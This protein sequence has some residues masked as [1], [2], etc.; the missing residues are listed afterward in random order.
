MSVEHRDAPTWPLFSAF[1]N[2]SE[3]YLS[4]TEPSEYFRSYLDVGVRGHKKQ[5][6]PPMGYGTNSSDQVDLK[7]NSQDYLEPSSML[8]DKCYSRETQE[9]ESTNPSTDADQDR[10]TCNGSLS[11]PAKSINDLCEDQVTDIRST[12]YCLNFSAARDTLPNTTFSSRPLIRGTQSVQSLSEDPHLHPLRSVA[13]PYPAGASYSVP[14][15][16]L[17]NQ[18]PETLA[19]LS[20]ASVNTPLGIS[21]PNYAGTL[22]KSDFRLPSS[23]TGFPDIPSSNLCCNPPAHDRTSYARPQMTVQ[24]N[25]MRN[26]CSPYYANA[27]EPY[28][29]HA[30]LSGGNLNTFH[31]S[32][33]SP[34]GRKSSY[35]IHRA[36]PILNSRLDPYQHFNSSECY[37]GRPDFRQPES[38]RRRISGISDFPPDSEQRLI[39]YGSHKARQVTGQVERLNTQK[40]RSQMNLA[41]KLNHDGQPSTH[42]DPVTLKLALP[43][44]SANGSACA[45]ISFWSNPAHSTAPLA[46]QTLSRSNGSEKRRGSQNSSRSSKRRRTCPDVDPKSRHQKLSQAS[47]MPTSLTIAR[48]LSRNAALQCIS[49][50]ALEDPLGL[51]APE[52]ALTRKLACHKLTTNP[53]AL[54]RDASS[55]ILLRNYGKKYSFL[56]F[57]LRA[58]TDVSSASLLSF[59][60]LG[61]QEVET[62]SRGNFLDD[63]ASLAL[64]RSEHSPPD[65]PIYSPRTSCG[66]EPD[67]LHLY[68]PTCEATHGSDDA[69]LAFRPKTNLNSAVRLKKGEEP[70]P[71]T[72]PKNTHD[73]YSEARRTVESL[74]SKQN[75]ASVCQF[76][77][78]QLFSTPINTG[79]G[80]AVFCS[81]TC[82]AMYES[83]TSKQQR[84]NKL[85]CIQAAPTNVFADDVISAVPILVHTSIPK[86]CKNAS[87]PAPVNKPNRRRPLPGRDFQPKATTRRWQGAR[88]MS[89]SSAEQPVAFSHVKTATTHQ[90]LSN[91]LR[92]ISFSSISDLH[93]TP[94]D[95]RLCGL[96]K[97]CGDADDQVAGRLLN[98]TRD[99]WM[100]VNCIL[101]C[102]DTYETLDGCLMNV[103]RSLKKA[104]EVKCSHCGLPGAGL[105]CFDADCTLLCH[106]QCARAL[107]CTFH[108][109]RSMFCQLHRNQ[110]QANCLDSLAVSRRV[111]LSRDEYSLVEDVIGS[112]SPLTMGQRSKL[113]IG[114]LILHSIGQLLSEHVDS[115][116]FHTKLFVY[117]VG[118]CTTR[119]YW[120]YRRPGRRCFYTCSIED[121]SC[122]VSSSQD[123]WLTDG[124]CGD[125]FKNAPTRPVFTVLVNDPGLPDEKFRSFLCNTVWQHI[126]QLVKIAR[127][128]FHPTALDLF[129]KELVGED[130]FGLSESHVVRAIESLPGIEHLRNYIFKFAKMQLISKMPLML[131]PTGC[132]RSEPKLRTYVR[133][134][135]GDIEVESRTALPPT[136]PPTSRL[137]DPHRCSQI[138]RTCNPLSYTAPIG[139]QSSQVPSKFY[140][141][142]RLRFEWKNNVLLARSKI[143][144]L[145]LFAARDIDKHEF[146]IEY[147]GQLI[148]NE[149][150]NLRERLYDS[151]NR[152]IYMFRADDDCI[153]DATMYGGL[154][155]YINHSC[156][157][158]CIAEVFAFEAN[159]RIIIIAK[160]LIKKGEELTYDYKFDFEDDKP[161]RIPCLCGAKQ[162]RKWMN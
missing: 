52:P 3:G 37:D 158:N 105:P 80:Q 145:G 87:K 90:P 25:F 133:N 48:L 14:E 72:C 26:Y 53:L 132:A 15:S 24:P 129:C 6:D 109:D 142:K 17:L 70:S 71:S 46:S 16:M 20:Y 12:S 115:G 112:Q 144:G 137:T 58:P 130:L 32:A 146:I 104:A 49:P 102:Y 76:C 68:E 18:A 81:E 61:A 41:G 30:S 4:S 91:W 138:P 27:A 62:V 77:A 39:E 92:P 110:A 35:H 43:R 152:G 73:L 139:K 135:T 159:K 13:P 121:S 47:E 7:D 85:S 2:N 33:S 84:L 149:V 124:L 99:H 89:Y 106:L 51:Y 118:F 56:P 75:C 23:S 161:S 103:A 114:S 100:H 154:A 157:P 10:F 5:V 120:S 134:M 44:E 29:T 36:S 28:P 88:W 19:S 108:E 111:F 67:Y 59:I 50:P 66:Q 128:T 45:P 82:R 42:V 65:L 136:V 127:K 151:Q 95:T 96:C 9:S 31:G 83:S 69:P 101:W 143:Q 155:R 11:P 125:P 131:N 74:R 98:Y 38:K 86:L 156:E 140:Q 64:A 55:S 122:T 21:P 63:A 150:G 123:K 79:R 1:G 60:G 162:C 160:R 22:P 93:S 116:R 34:T 148:R 94:T 147:L 57:S 119:I 78:M 141:Y 54:Q 117:P 107:D 126:L 97:K 8:S 40:F 113:R 153:V